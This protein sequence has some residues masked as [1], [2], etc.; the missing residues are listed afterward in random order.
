M[1]LGHCAESLPIRSAPNVQ[2]LGAEQHLSLACFDKG[3]RIHQGPVV[4]HDGRPAARS[5]RGS[6]KDAAGLLPELALSVGAMV[7]YKINS[8]TSRSVIHGLLCKVIE[9]VYK[10]GEKPLG[11]KGPGKEASLPLVIFVEAQGYKG[12]SYE[13]LDLS[14][15]ERCRQGYRG[16]FPVLP[17]ERKWTVKNVEVTRRMFPLELGWARSIH[18][19][20]G[21]TAGP[22]KPITSYLLDIG[23]TE[24]SAGLSYVGASRAQGPAVYAVANTANGYAF[25]TEER[26]KNI[27]ADGTNK[28]KEIDLRLRQ[29]ESRRLSRLSDLTRESNAQLFA[30]CQAEVAT[31]STAVEVAT[32]AK[33]DAR[34]DARPAARPDEDSG[35]PCNVLSTWAKCPVCKQ[36][37]VEESSSSKVPF[38]FFVGG[39]LVRCHACHTVRCNAACGCVMFNTPEEPAHPE[40]ETV[41]VAE[42]AGPV[43]APREEVLRFNFGDS[44][45][46]DEGASDAG[47]SDAGSDMSEESH[48]SFASSHAE[49]GADSDVEVSNEPTGSVQYRY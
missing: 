38:L 39:D 9:I 47:A 41:L 8:W 4:Q 28:K 23:N 21:C 25:P 49:E 18:K 7:I 48:T 12:P 40:G 20:Q 6:Q 10:T 34:P 42:P 17:V 13:H 16:V 15:R 14:E 3:D 36:R 2:V 43:S 46:S 26:F 37:E 33:L 11:T 45:V 29:Q 22:E 19:S 1:V 35:C 31:H 27:G 24:L 44:D 5:E 30:W 32:H